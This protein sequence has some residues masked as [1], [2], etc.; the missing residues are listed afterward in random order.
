MD[1]IV[2]TAL[3]FTDNA[4]LLSQASELRLGNSS[5]GVLGQV[6]GQSPDCSPSRSPSLLSYSSPPELPR[7]WSTALPLH[8]SALKSPPAFNTL[9]S[10]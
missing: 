8:S 5:A 10:F 2:K 9:N 1:Q 3:A 6:K 7:A 4:T